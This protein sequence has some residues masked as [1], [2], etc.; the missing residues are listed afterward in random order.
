MYEIE[1]PGV[2]KRKWRRNKK[3]KERSRMNRE[4]LWKKGKKSEG[5]TLLNTKAEEG[6]PTLDF[7]LRTFFLFL[8][9]INFFLK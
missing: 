1:H 7:G 6:L 2:Q 3:A 8:F 4:E 9:F 5:V